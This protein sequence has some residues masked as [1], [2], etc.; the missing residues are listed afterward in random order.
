[1]LLYNARPAETIHFM[2]LA[3][4]TSRPA[5]VL[6]PLII[7]ELTVIHISIG[8]ADDN[9]PNQNIHFRKERELLFL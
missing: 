2:E 8:A 4:H 9:F 1:M 7:G 3:L 5:T 6:V